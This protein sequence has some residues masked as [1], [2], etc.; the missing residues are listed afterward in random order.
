M[1]FTKVHCS[2]LL[3]GNWLANCLESMYFK[4][5]YFTNLVGYLYWVTNS[6]LFLSFVLFCFSQY[7]ILYHQKTSVPM[8]GITPSDFAAWK[9]SAEIHFGH[10]SLYLQPGWF[11]SPSLSSHLAPLWDLLP[12]SSSPSMIWGTCYWWIPG[13]FPHHFL[14]PHCYWSSLSEIVS[15]PNPKLIE[16]TIY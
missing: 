11:L 6:H 10:T 2:F 1:L 12:S 15:F 13:Q 5:L 3:S 8:P 14:L 7:S 16:I 9:F 4:C